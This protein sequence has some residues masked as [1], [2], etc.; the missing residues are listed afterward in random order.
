MS[1]DFSADGTAG[2]D[3][4]LE[5]G[6]TL[7]GR[8]ERLELDG[9]L[10]FLA[11]ALL[12]LKLHSDLGSQQAAG[13]KPAE[14]QGSQQTAEWPGDETMQ[15]AKRSGEG[16]KEGKL[17][18]RDKYESPG[19]DVERAGWAGVSESCAGIATAD[20]GEFWMERAGC[21]VHVYLPHRKENSVMSVVVKRNRS[22]EFMGRGM[23]ASSSTAEFT[24]MR[25]GAG[26]GGER[27]VSRSGELSAALQARCAMSQRCGAT[28]TILR[29]KLISKVS[30]SEAERG[31]V[32]E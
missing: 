27:V 30:Q 7:T 6:E 5:E 3:E 26:G 21:G 10:R 20:G 31:A 28:V 18:H 8:L 19:G 1:D 4:L 25:A 17:R 22:R 24:L 23:S 13:I 12:E 9:Q 11:D 14:R 15:I 32:G 2:R 29:I 16:L